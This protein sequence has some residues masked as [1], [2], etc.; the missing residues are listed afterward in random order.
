M[1]MRLQPVAKHLTVNGLALHY[2]DWSAAGAPPDALPVVCVHGYTS[3]AQ[4]FSA[5]AR[6]LCDRARIIAVDVRG[7]GE[8]QWSGEGAYRYADQ[9][10]DLAAFVDRLGLDRFILVGTS[11]GG[12]IAM[13]YAVRHPRRLLALA[14]N[15]IGPDAELGSSRITTMV[16]NRP[17]SFPNLEAAL[18]YRRQTSPIT[19]AR[20]LEDQR[21][22]A[23]GVLR[24][25]PDGS[26]GW[27]MDPA[28]IEQRLT[29]AAQPPP[30]SWTALATLPCPTQIIWGTDSD[31]L[32]ETQARRMVETLPKG[33][34]V[35]VHGVGHAP[36]LVEPEALSALERL[37]AAA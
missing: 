10:G 34:L 13:A 26:W 24:E 23:L 8:S 37:L 16:G 17:D 1:T 12:R 6:R 15:D 18:E 5:M 22:T 28:Y 14:L 19:A 29:R 31:V 11:M 3:S 30:V 4:A 36:T 9:A 27:K 25:R 33:E 7:H 2:L 21:E 32:S 20:P 35:T